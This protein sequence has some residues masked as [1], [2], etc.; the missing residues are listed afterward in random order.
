MRV[1]DGKLKEVGAQFED[2][3]LSLIPRYCLFHK[4]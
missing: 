4:A 3:Y 2:R 1:Q